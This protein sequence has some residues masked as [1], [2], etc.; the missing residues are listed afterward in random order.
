MP[1]LLTVTGLEIPLEPNNEYIL[2]RGLDCDIVVLDVVSSRRH[3]KLVL[4]ES[5]TDVFIEDLNSKN[6]TWINEVRVLRRTRLKDGSSIRIGATVYLLNLLDSGASDLRPMLE[7]GT[8]AF[9]ALSLGRG[10]GSEIARVVRN[11]GAAPTDFAGQLGAFSLVEI[12][13]LLT[14]TRRSGTLHLALSA[15]HARV[16]I[17]NGEVISATFDNLEGFDALLALAPHDQGLFWLVDTHRSVDRTIDL[18][19]SRLLLELCSALD[20]AGN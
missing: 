14:Q 19:A 1:T 2:G 7:T 10:V 3:A 18:P 9:E 20:E 6:G 17:R 5:V 16:E 12:L 15:G 13:Q 11:E 8:E 4:G